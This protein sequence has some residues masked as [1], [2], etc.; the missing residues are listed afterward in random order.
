MAP[1]LFAVGGS[2]VAL[3]FAAWL[4]TVSGVFRFPTLFSRIWWAVS[5]VWLAMP[6][7]QE[8]PFYRL[9]RG[10]FQQD[11]GCQLLQL[12]KCMKPDVI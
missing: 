10:S 7:T 11:Q 8:E 6:T 2:R 4:R 3:F 12:S 5:T 1:R 9:R